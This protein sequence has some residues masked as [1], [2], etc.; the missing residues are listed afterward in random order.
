MLNRTRQNTID[1]TLE[2]VKTSFKMRYQN[3]VLGFLWVLIKPY[4]M[5][6]V[7]Y[8]IFANAERSNV[9]NFGIYL[10]IGNVFISFVS[11]MLTQGQMALLD[12]AHII[13][14]VNF[15]RQIAVISSLIGALIN[16]GI[17]VVLILVIALLSKLTFNLS[18]LLVILLVICILFIWLLAISFFLS[19]LT[20][21]LRDLKNITELGIFL[22]QFATPIFYTLEDS[23][24]P[25]SVRGVVALNPLGFLFNQIRGSIGAYTGSYSNLD[26]ISLLVYF[27]L[28]CLAAYFGWLYFDRNVKYVAEHF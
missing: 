21:R 8:M 9:I 7:M 6:L 19:I 23:F 25:R 2:L 5:F 13:L 28:G 17:N 27:L 22:L 18:A 12:R 4:A 14:K 16:V 3:S 15:S 11:E 10:L 20:V 26:T 1:L 24:L